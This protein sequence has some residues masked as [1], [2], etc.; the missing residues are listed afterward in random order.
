MRETG[1]RSKRFFGKTHTNGTNRTN[2]AEKID[3]KIKTKTPPGLATGRGNRGMGVRHSLFPA[4]TLGA[5]LAVAAGFPTLFS[6]ASGVFGLVAGPSSVL[7]RLDF[8]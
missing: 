5:H 2:G 3:G 6:T 7:Q 8:E 4:P 1:G